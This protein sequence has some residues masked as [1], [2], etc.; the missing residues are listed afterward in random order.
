MM[1]SVKEILSLYFLLNRH[2]KKRCLEILSVSL[3]CFFIF[4]KGG[5]YIGTFSMLNR[6]VLFVFG[7]KCSLY[8]N[9]D[10]I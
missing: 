5:G 3:L 9:G 4:S 2:S 7:L 6:E 10:K 8:K 1:D